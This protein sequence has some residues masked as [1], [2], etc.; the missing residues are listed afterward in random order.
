VHAAGVVADHASERAAIVRGGIG[1]EGKVVLLG[2]GTEA[3]KDDSRLDARDA[4][5][6][7]DFKN[8][9]HVLRKVEDN[10]G[11][12]ALSGKRSTS[13]AGQ[14]WSAVLAAEGNRGQH[15]FFVA[16]NYDADRNLA[17]I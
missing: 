13:A 15:V 12:A 9:R 7:I 2:C 4:A 17:V 8:A 1:R 11:V 3:I 6:G 10:G 5:L 16:R 14:Q